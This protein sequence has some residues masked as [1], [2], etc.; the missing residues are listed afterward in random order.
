MNITKSIV[1]VIALLLF[2]TIQ[3]E[4]KK[5]D[6]NPT[7]VLER[8]VAESGKPEINEFYLKKSEEQDGNP[9]KI[10]VGVSGIVK[11]KSPTG[12]KLDEGLMEIQLWFSVDNKLKA[13]EI[14]NLLGAVMAS[15]NQDSYE[16][17]KKAEKSLRKEGA[18][19]FIIDKISFYDYEF[20]PISSKNP[21]V[22]LMTK[23]GYI[24]QGGL[25]KV[26]DTITGKTYNLK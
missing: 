1:I 15:H 2:I 9:Y 4:C 3:G 6:A 22:F 14:S 23:E 21:L 26:K 20:E 13:Q 19:H 12:R 5:N 24:Y 18:K 16:L 11:H 17:R 7:I 25:G 8:I 10:V